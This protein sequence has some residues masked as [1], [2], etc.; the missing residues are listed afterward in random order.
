L[1]LNK[2]TPSALIKEEPKLNDTDYT[3]LWVRDGSCLLA[4]RGSDSQ[5]DV[6]MLAK[7]PDGYG[8]N[9]NGKPGAPN[10]VQWNTVEFHGL[11][12][13]EGVKVE[14]EALLAKMASTNGLATIKEKC[15][16]GLTLTGHSLGGGTSQLMATL[17]NKKGDPLGAELTVD[18]V[19]GFGPMPFAKGAP[20]AND[21]SADGCFAG[22]MYANAKENEDLVPMVDLVWQMLTTTPGL[23]F[24]HVKT[25]HHLLLGPGDILVTPCGE[26][27]PYLPDAL[28]KGV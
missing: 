13:H 21:K 8:Q 22:G 10:G 9:Y 19:F 2:T 14:L 11:D 25:A 3:G 27:P 26:D 17:L 18:H 16:A 5:I 4:F 23:Q 24:R 7:A 1:V 12:V 28:A 20:A 6:G 15:T